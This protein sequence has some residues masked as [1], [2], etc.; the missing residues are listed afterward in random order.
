[1]NCIDAIEKLNAE[2][3]TLKSTPAKERLFRL[4]D[5]GSFTELD[6]FQKNSGGLCEVYT[7]YGFVGGSPAYA[8]SQDITVSYG[9]MGRMQAKKIKRIYL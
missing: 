8:F 9:A 3:A 2:K 1:M 5:D 6:K 7:A 4:F